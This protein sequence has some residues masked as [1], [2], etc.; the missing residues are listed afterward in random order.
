[1]KKSKSF[2]FPYTDEEWQL[3][4]KNGTKVTGVGT[5]PEMW[6]MQPAQ[7]EPLLVTH[8]SRGPDKCLK[9]AEA[10]APPGVAYAFAKANCC[11]D[12]IC[13]GGHTEDTPHTPKCVQAFRSN[14][15]YCLRMGNVCKYP[16]SQDACCNGLICTFDERSRQSTCILAPHAFGK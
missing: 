14:S 4:F 7:A 12:L 5:P 11:Q 13:M 8:D 6:V 16:Q 15:Q 10:C 1:M 3:V 9:T 2:S